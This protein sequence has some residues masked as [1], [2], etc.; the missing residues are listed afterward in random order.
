MRATT[1]A[2]RAFATMLVLTTLATLIAIIVRDGVQAWAFDR[3]RHD[4]PNP[5]TVETTA[6]GWRRTGSSRR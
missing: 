1:G 6:T 5:V 4:A 3:S 2:E